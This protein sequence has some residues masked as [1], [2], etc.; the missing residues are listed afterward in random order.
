MSRPT[1]RAPTTPPRC[2][3]ISPSSWIHAT[4]TDDLM[5]MVMEDKPGAYS[6]CK[7]IC[8]FFSNNK[9]TRAVQ[10]EAEFHGLQ[11]SD[12]SASAYYHCLK[13]LAD[14]LADYDQPLRN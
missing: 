14:A 1:T 5:D 8:D 6:V 9:E 11:Q 2:R 13:T 12:M 10:L 3:H 7:T 4:L